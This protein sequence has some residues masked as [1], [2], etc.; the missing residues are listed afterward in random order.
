[1]L[2]KHDNKSLTA[3]PGKVECPGFVRTL[4]HNMVNLREIRIARKK[5]NIYKLQYLPRGRGPKEIWVIKIAA[6]SWRDLLA[7]HEGSTRTHEFS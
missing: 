2:P 7:L 5:R 3:F 1:M 6:C 4:L